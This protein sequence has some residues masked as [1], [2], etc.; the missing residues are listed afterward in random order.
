MGLGGFDDGGSF[1]RRCALRNDAV[2]AHTHQADAAEAAAE[3]AEMEKDGSGSGSG[4]S[5]KA[6]A[7]TAL[8]ACLR[9]QVRC[10]FCLCFVGV[11]VFSGSSSLYDYHH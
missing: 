1:F 5:P 11:W 4:G 3:E 7:T 10:S 2:L 9:W 8:P 6:A